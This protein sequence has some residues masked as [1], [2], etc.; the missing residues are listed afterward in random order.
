M[1]AQ[2]VD[3]LEEQVADSVYAVLTRDGYM[4]WRPQA[5]TR[6]PAGPQHDDLVH[7]SSAW[8][9]VPMPG[10][11]VSLLPALEL[12]TPAGALNDALRAVHART[13]I[14][15]TYSD[16]QRYWWGQL[17]LATSQPSV[18]TAMT[19]QARPS[20]YVPQH[21]LHLPTT[22]QAVA[23]NDAYARFVA[24]L[25][26]EYDHQGWAWPTFLDPPAVVPPAH[27]RR[28][29]GSKIVPRID[30]LPST[31]AECVMASDQGLSGPM[32]RAQRSTTALYHIISLLYGIRGV[33]A[34]PGYAALALRGLRTISDK[35]TALFKKARILS[36]PTRTRQRIGV[37]WQRR[38]NALSLAGFQRPPTHF[39]TSLPS[40]R[41]ELIEMLRS[42]ATPS[43]SY[44][45]I[46][47]K[48]SLRLLYPEA[49]RQRYLD[50]PALPTN[51]NRHLI[52]TLLVTD[53]IND[54][55]ANLHMGHAVIGQDQWSS[56]SCLRPSAAA[57][58]V[59]DHLA[60]RLEPVIT[61][62]ERL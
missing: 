6:Q 48:K 37:I 46:G 11:L 4:A 58:S 32:A 49:M 25:R 1:T 50:I 40:P 16:L 15:L 44:I 31:L 7:P 21:Y 42:Q 55:H 57:S 45:D 53:R 60:S 36:L 9:T 34:R 43:L 61:R 62:L 22:T 17:A 38:A 54:Q 18:A 20:T 51:W 52:R 59:V 29:Y 14:R 23:Y 19:G 27:D 47:S 39:I 56:T 5:L 3:H 28:G 2:V 41:A 12:P 8:I 35:D 24:C 33:R 26:A 13:G 10:L 30:R